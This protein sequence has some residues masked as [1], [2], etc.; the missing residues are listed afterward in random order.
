M[1]LAGLVELGEFSTRARGRVPARLMA[2]GIEAAAAWALTGRPLRSTRTDARLGLG[3]AGSWRTLSVTLAYRTGPLH[4]LWRAGW[5]PRD[6]TGGGA[7]LHRAY[8]TATTATVAPAPEP[9]GGP[10][11]N[12]AGA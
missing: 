4:V 1:D 2:S 9:G 3:T 6:S 8:L 12:R 11:G 10:R 5:H 7:A